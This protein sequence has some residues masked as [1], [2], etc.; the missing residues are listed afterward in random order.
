MASLWFSV[1]SGIRRWNCGRAIERARKGF[2]RNT[3]R[4]M[5]FR[6]ATSMKS[7]TDKDSLVVQSE[8]E[9]ERGI[10]TAN[11]E[12][13]LSSL[14][15]A[16]ARVRMKKTVSFADESETIVSSDEVAVMELRNVLVQQSSMIKEL[17]RLLDE[18]EDEN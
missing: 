17:G 7:S 1:A 10:A 13:P 9:M 18:D 16:D 3:A 8:K 15:L 2:A 11:G 5:R 14:T 4:M 12:P 6:S